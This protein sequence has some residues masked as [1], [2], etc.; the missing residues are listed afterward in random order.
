MSKIGTTKKQNSAVVQ[1]IN[2]C[3]IFVSLIKSASRQTDYAVSS[4]TLWG[5]ENFQDDSD[6]GVM[7]INGQKPQNRHCQ[8]SALFV[9]QGLFQ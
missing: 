2:G 6:L 7:P 9:E 8:N 5:G 1:P 4:K 3:L